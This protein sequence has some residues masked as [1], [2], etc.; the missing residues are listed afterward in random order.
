MREGLRK[1]QMGKREIKR[2]TINEARRETSQKEREGERKGEVP[3][4]DI[5]TNRQ[6]DTEIRM[7]ARGKQLDSRGVCGR[8]T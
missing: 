2:Q 3:Y 8:K 6:T 7:Q 5:Q 4:G 1:V